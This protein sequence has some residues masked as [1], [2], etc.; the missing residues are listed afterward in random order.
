MQ[1]LKWEYLDYILKL[2]HEKKLSDYIKAIKE[3]EEK[4]RAWYADKVNM[5]KNL[6]RK[7]LLIDGCFIL[8]LIHGIEGLTPQIAGSSDHA[9]S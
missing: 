3:I 8:H 5:E 1:N 4:V 9:N 2:N 6:F 7:M